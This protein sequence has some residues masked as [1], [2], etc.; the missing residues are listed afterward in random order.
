MS[1]DHWLF[2]RLGWRPAAPAIQGRR[3]IRDR[4]DWTFREKAP[5]RRIRKY[6]TRLA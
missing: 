6:G 3:L 1:R 2:H 5:P 4:Q